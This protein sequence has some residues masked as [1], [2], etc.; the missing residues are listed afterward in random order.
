MAMHCRAWNRS[1]LDW[2]PC[3]S[4][5]LQGRMAEAKRYAQP[6][7][8]G[9]A[10]QPRSADFQASRLEPLERRLRSASASRG[11]MIGWANPMAVGWPDGRAARSPLW[12]ALKRGWP[13]VA[14]HGCLASRLEPLELGRSFHPTGWPQIARIFRHVSKLGGLGL[15]GRTLPS[16]LQDFP[17][18]G[19]SGWAGRGRG[20]KSGVRGRKSKST[21]TPPPNFSP[22][23]K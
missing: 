14:T 16:Y 5:G 12:P 21:H 11:S 18:A 6:M 3:V 9:L 8:V 15:H 20:S 2:P 1:S 17:G 7:A 22:K 4:A 23:T 13:A 19:L 10:V